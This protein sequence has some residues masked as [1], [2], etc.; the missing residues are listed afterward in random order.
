M[1]LGSRIKFGGI[2]PSWQLR[3]WRSGSGRCEDKWMD[4]HII[5]EGKITKSDIVII[6]EN[7]K[8]LGWWTDKHNRYASREVVDMLIER[9]LL[10][11]DTA[12]DDSRLS[13]QALVRRF[14]KTELYFRMPPLIR[15]SLYFIYRYLFRLGFLDG[16]PGF[17]FHALQGFWYRTLVDAKLKQV[18]DYCK[19][20]NVTIEVAVLDVLEIDLSKKK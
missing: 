19:N 10:L 3:F 20:H 4:E 17:Y 2:E 6:D 15:S 7:V 11:V 9:R 12:E 5:V 14:L 16:T 13:R 18:I 8:S 1:F